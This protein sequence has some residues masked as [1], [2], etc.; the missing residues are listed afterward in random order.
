MVYAD[1]STAPVVI[2]P[3]RP[4]PPYCGGPVPGGFPSDAAAADAA[5]PG[6]V[7][8]REEVVG[9]YQLDIIGGTDPMAVRDWLQANGYTV[10]A[11]AAPIIDYYTAQ[12]SDF[13]ALRLRP[14]EGI[15]R[16]SPVRVTTPGMNPALPLRM[17]GAGVGDHVG[18]LLTVIS[19]G[20][21][22]AMNFPNGEIN[23]QTLTYDFA[24][25][26][27]PARDYLAAFTAL[28]TDAGGG[29]G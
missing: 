5:D 8:H 7:V 6:V 23:E 2:P 11:A 12:H 29:Y 18:L 28:N 19:G 3:P 13:L 22:E 20:R 16:M 1:S 9:P 21:M 4:Q 10:P 27:D 15:D 25:P 26:N 17:I 14:G 24:A